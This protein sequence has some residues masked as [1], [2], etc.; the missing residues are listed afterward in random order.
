MT[1]KELHSFD[2]A[3]IWHPFDSLHAQNILIESAEGVY[4]KTSD[5]KLIL[6]AV[7]SWWV[8]IHGHGRKEIA[9]AIY[10]Q[11]LQL[12]HVIF[13]GFTH[14]PAIELA[15]KLLRILP[16][17]Y[18]Q[19]FYS[20]NGSTCVEVAIKLALQYWYNIEQPK[21]KIIGLE[22]AYHGDTFGAMSVGERNQFTKPFQQHLFQVDTI[23]VFAVTQE[24]CIAAFES[25]IKQDDVAA[26]IYEPLLQ[27]S[28]GMR[29][30]SSELLDKLILTA[31]RYNVIC[32]ADEVLT[33]FGRTG[34]LFASDYCSE[35]PDIICMSK[36]ITGGFLPLGVTAINKKIIAA[37]NS[38]ERNK[39]FYHGHSYTANPISCAAA[40]ASIDI[41]LSEECTT[42]IRM[43]EQQHQ[44][45]IRNNQKNPKIKSI[46]SL[47]TVLSIE[48][49]TLDKTSYFNSKRN[50][51][52]QFF[53]DRG[54]LMR[55]LGNVIYILPPYIIKPAQLNQIYDAINELLNIW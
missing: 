24:E 4:L 26:F 2:I 55:P 41:L 28:A 10:Q 1:N 15:E 18:D 45:Y 42:Q 9:E 47:G 16:F 40:N 6:D 46:H 50:E 52:Y 38:T 7:S 36:G 53:M 17:E 30:Y 14:R 33:G 54:I 44:E 51:L 25:K 8:N 5:G 48:L 31:K 34:K 49:Q 21:N 12:E 29:I 43:I 13:A 20:D 35:A 39:R 27:G 32:I 23:D 11:A 3:H 22:G 37:Y 19:I